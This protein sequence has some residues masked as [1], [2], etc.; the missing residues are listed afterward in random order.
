MASHRE[1]VFVKGLWVDSKPSDFK[2]LGVSS[3]PLKSM[4][5]MFGQYC[6]EYSNDFM[7]CK[8]NKDPKECLLPGRKVTRCA[9][10][11]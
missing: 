6:K 10:D 4:A 2:E 7:L 3:A 1:G 8:A 9:Q 5:F 11:L